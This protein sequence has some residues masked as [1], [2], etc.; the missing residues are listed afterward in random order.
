MAQV[1]TSIYCK[2]VEVE[3]RQNI[4][5]LKLQKSL[6]GTLWYDL[7]FYQKIVKDM[8]SQGFDTN[9]YDPS[10]VNKM[11]SGKQM[12]ILQHVDDLNISYIDRKEVTQ[13]I[14]RIKSVYVDNIQV[15]QGKKHN[16]LGI[17]LDFDVT[18]NVRVIIVE[19]L[20]KAIVDLTYYIIETSPTLA[21]EHLF[22]VF[23]T[24]KESFWKRNGQQNST[25]VQHSFYQRFSRLERISKQ[26]LI[27]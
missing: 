20:K 27:S 19:Y 6:Y 25:T 1:N 15:S 18:G 26:P 4:L 21:Q 3:N 13:I 7:I 2:Y 8:E 14:K 23:P 9:P 16:Y 17:D 11:L 12:A 24:S 5:Y 22:E 10:V